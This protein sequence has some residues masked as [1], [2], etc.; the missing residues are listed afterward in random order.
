MKK[1]VEISHPGN[2]AAGGLLLDFGRGDGDEES[3]Q[4]DGPDILGSRSSR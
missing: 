4:S 1:R 3:V 2:A